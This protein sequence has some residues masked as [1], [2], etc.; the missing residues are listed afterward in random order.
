MILL[1]LSQR[2]QAVLDGFELIFVVPQDAQATVDNDLLVIDDQYFHAHELLPLLAVSATSG[3]RM[4]GRW[5]RNVDPFPTSLST[6]I[7]PPWASTIPWLTDNPSP[8]PIPILGG[9]KGIE[10][11]PEVFLGYSASG[12]GDR[13]FH[14]RHGDGAGLRRSRLRQPP[15]A[16]DDAALSINRML[17][18][19][20]QVHDDLLDLV[21]IDPDL[22]QGAIEIQGDGDI[23]QI[24]RP[25]DKTRGVF[26]DL[27]EV[28]E[29]LLRRLLPGE[30][31]Q[32]S[33]DAGAPLGL[34]DHQVHVLGVLAAVLHLFPQQDREGKDA[35]QRIVQFMRDAGGKQSDRSQ[36]FA[37]RGFGLG[38]AELLG[39]LLDLLL[40]GARPLAQ[41]RPG[42]PQSRRH[43][44]EG[45]RKLAELV[46]APHRNRLFQIP[47]RDPLRPGFQVAQRQVDQTVDEKAYR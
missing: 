7:V 41:L 44:I 9:E 47:G 27:V 10:N 26:D 36:L 8:V 46:A 33:D 3:D 20:Q 38:N 30:I 13:K 19:D 16:D 12:I 39:S 45:V 21:R 32:P 23:A 25:F 28:G 4:R 11:P 2:L 22:R 24:G 43:G 29:F 5:T 40:Q 17:G 37:P 14:H 1:D 18:V 34:P 31:E 15:R 42:I 6:S 35:G